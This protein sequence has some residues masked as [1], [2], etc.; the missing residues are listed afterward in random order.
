MHV[1]N[2]INTHFSKKKKKHLKL[3]LDQNYYLYKGNIISNCIEWLGSSN[4]TNLTLIPWQ[5]FFCPI[6]K[7]ALYL[8][9]YLIYIFKMIMIFYNGIFKINRKVFKQSTA[10]KLLCFYLWKKIFPITKST[11][12][13]MIGILLK[14]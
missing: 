5:L 3:N 13:F 14:L 10:F 6:V 1:K 11:S 8:Y 12:G 4:K 7:L 2:K 9:F